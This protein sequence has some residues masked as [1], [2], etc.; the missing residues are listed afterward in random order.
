VDVKAGRRQLRGDGLGVR[1]V[2]AGAVADQNQ[3]LLGVISRG[4]TGG[5]L[6]AAGL[7]LGTAV[8]SQSDAGWLTRVAATALIDV[9]LIRVKKGIGSVD[10]QQIFERRGI[11]TQAAF[12][13]GVD[14]K[15]G[16]ADEVVGIIRDHIVDELLRRLFQRSFG[17]QRVTGR[18]TLAGRVLVGTWLQQGTGLVDH[19][20]EIT[21][22]RHVPSARGDGFGAG[23]VTRV[24]QD[25][26]KERVEIP[27]SGHAD[28]V[29]FQIRADSR[30]EDL[31]DWVPAA[32]FD[33]RDHAGLVQLEVVLRHL[34][35]FVAVHRRFATFQ[36]GGRRQC[37]GVCGV[38]RHGT[39]VDRHA[40]VDG[41]REQAHQYN[42]HQGEQD[43]D[44]PFATPTEALPTLG[45]SGPNGIFRR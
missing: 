43:E 31:K 23:R 29:H 45:V 18:R 8:K 2:G 15:A 22:P 44:G 40:D 42:D 19:Q 37:S 32:H 16:D 13:S 35:S 5:D 3:D 30:I 36:N 9:A 6:A 27:L 39:V 11:V 41:E 24:P 12:Q 4:R 34:P 14:S 38:L 10:I 1:I 28:R 33:L 21:R 25:P 26:A 7:A 17:V 20:D